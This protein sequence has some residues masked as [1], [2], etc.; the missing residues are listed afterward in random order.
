MGV[1]IQMISRRTLFGLA[2]PAVTALLAFPKRLFASSSARRQ[3][4]GSTT[5][6]CPFYNSESFLVNGQPVATPKKI[7]AVF[8][9][10]DLAMRLHP[11]DGGFAVTYVGVCETGIA[12]PLTVLDWHLSPTDARLLETGL[13]TVAER[14]DALATECQARY[15]SAG[16]FIKA[17]GVGAILM[18]HGVRQGLHIREIDSELTEM[19]RAELVVHTSTPVHYGRVKFSSHAYEKIVAYEGVPK[20]H[21]FNQVVTYAIGDK[22][23]HGSCLD[24]FLYAIAIGLWNSENPYSRNE[25]AEL[26]SEGSWKTLITLIKETT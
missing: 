11:A 2:I 17:T 16:M 15:G 13:S 9:V 8:A 18:Q 26:V 12:Y 22:R 21:L 14:L 20:N 24:T 1:P 3:E 25:Q 7:D 4:T 6:K 19:G 5:T 10:I 23:D